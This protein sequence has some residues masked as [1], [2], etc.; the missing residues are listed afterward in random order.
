MHA[1][2]GGVAPPHECPQRERQQRA[3]HDEGGQ[4]RQREL[5]QHHQD[6]QHH[7]ALRLHHLH[8]WQSG[9]HTHT[10]M[11][12]QP[13]TSVRVPTTATNA[14]ALAQYLSLEPHERCPSPACALT[15]PGGIR[16]RAGEEERYCSS[17]QMYWANAT[18]LCPQAL[19]GSRHSAVLAQQERQQSGVLASPVTALAP[20]TGVGAALNTGSSANMRPTCTQYSKWRG[21]MC[22]PRAHVHP[23]AQDMT[24]SQAPVQ[25][26][27]PHHA[28]PCP[29]ACI[30]RCP[31]GRQSSHCPR[32]SQPYMRH[33]RVERWMRVYSTLRCMAAAHLIRSC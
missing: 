16:P 12:K 7:A 28:R 26:A 29:C 14:V 15:P 19:Q 27:P 2:R 32:P 21:A 8:I 33:L 22:D 17:M 25:A 6:G 31:C 20:G 18:A 23:L 5:E 9:A 4:Q 3:P 13:G 10:R 30:F 24:S 1:R 11:R